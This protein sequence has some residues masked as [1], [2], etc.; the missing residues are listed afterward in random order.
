VLILAKYLYFAQMELEKKIT[1]F[2]QR[3]HL[4]TTNDDLLIAVSGGCDSVV[5]AHLLY[6][7]KYNIAIA[8][9]N[10]QLRADESDRDALFVKELATT[11]NVPFFIQNFDTK[12][13]ELEHKVNTQVAA[14]QLRYEYFNNLI[15]PITNKPF[16][17]ILT[18]H[19]TNDNIETV[20]MNFF[21]GTGI[22]GLHGILPKSN[23]LIR[24]LLYATREELENYALQ[25]EINFIQDSSN[26]SNKYARNFIRNEVL[27]LVQQKYP[28]VVQNIAKQI[29]VF[30]EVETIYDEAISIKK[31]KLSEHKG[32]EIFIPIFKLLKEKAFTT[33]L[34][35]IVL[36]YNFTT[37][38]LPD[39]VKLL[40][41]EN[42]KH[43]DSTTHRI[44]KNRNWLVITPLQTNQ[45]QYI[46]IEKKDKIVTFEN[47]TLHIESKYEMPANLNASVAYVNSGLLSFPLLLRK[48]KEGDYF[49][50]LGMQKKKKIARFL[51]DL[52]L[53]KTE[54][55]KIWVL[56]TNKKI[57]WI[58]NYRIDDRFKIKPNNNEITK[59]LFVVNTI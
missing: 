25:N 16:S 53:S 29:A 40:E 47:G 48:W 55:E 33:I 23:N 46:I 2:V 24:P 8:H 52:K 10:F 56:E 17:L 13:Y 21:K 31:V 43:V 36:E 57:V 3:N 39:V 12:K 41:A 1:N 26:E 27:P 22:S 42:S 5:L 51:I 30:T 7:L 44:F 59:F 58:L 11:L 28:Q 50:P 32:N 20:L 54:K 49:Y 6:K 34:Y 45:T 37:G 14:R 35:E 15:N 9:C 38:Q 19:H 4:F 18:A